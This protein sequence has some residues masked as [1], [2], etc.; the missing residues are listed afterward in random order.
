[1]G[2][3]FAGATVA[4][5][6]E[7]AAAWTI[8]S[9]GRVFGPSSGSATA[10]LAVGGAVTS[11]VE[12]GGA[13][14]VPAVRGATGGLRGRALEALAGEGGVGREHVPVAPG[15]VVFG[16]RG[17]HGE[18]A[19]ECP[20]VP[21]RLVGNDLSV[22][23]GDTVSPSKRVRRSDFDSGCGHGSTNGERTH[24]QLD[25]VVEA[26]YAAQDS[27]SRSVSSTGSANLDV[28]ASAGSSL[29]RACDGGLTFFTSAVGSAH[30]A[31][32]IHPHIVRHRFSTVKKFP[33]V[34]RLLRVFA[35]GSPVCAARGGNLTAE[36]AYGNH[37]S[38]AP[39]AV[40]VHQNT[41]ADVVHS[42]A[43]ALRLSSASDIRGLRVLPLAVA[44]KP[45]FRM[46]YDLRFARAGGHSSV[47][48]DIG[49]SSAPSCNLGHVLRDVLL[50]VLFLRQMHGP[51]ARIVLCRVNVKDA[52]GQ[53]LVDPVGAPVFGYAMG[54]YVVVDLR[55]QFG[56]RDS[57]GF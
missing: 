5:A 14:R 3:T 10:A 4:P 30:L 18:P 41:C 34:E 6:V 11:T 26:G 31:P 45:K 52:F 57:P 17:N 53:V 44:L 28:V 20:L 15:S 7:E 32:H 40:A 35:P 37:P 2:P 46:I 19:R 27:V 16:N 54:G 49:F 38:V 50:G 33:G 13:P 56:W 39:P 24:A 25:L 9:G 12:T 36:L 1:M 51:T 22:A 47:N 55:L 48:D 23:R 29:L 21:A 42:R 43:L 8:E